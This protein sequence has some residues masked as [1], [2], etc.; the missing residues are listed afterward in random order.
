LGVR[1]SNIELRKPFADFEI[2]PRKPFSKSEIGHSK[3]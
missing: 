1:F 3:P 2:G